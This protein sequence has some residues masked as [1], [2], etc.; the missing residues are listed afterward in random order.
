MCITSLE[1]RISRSSSFAQDVLTYTSA[2][3]EKDLAAVGPVKVK[4]WAKSS[5][6]DTDFVVK[7]VDV[8]PSGFAQNI[9]ERVIRARFRRG[10]KLPPQLMVPG[11]PYEF[12]LDLGYAGSLFKAGHRVRLDIASSK[13]PHLARNQNTGGHPSTDA[14]MEVA[15]NSILHGPAHP[16]YVELSIVPSLETANR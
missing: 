5:A 11:Q 15:A 12:E 1:R 6:R 4:F 3:L 2:P 16:S 9:L 7:L 14:R 13:F 8:R 10:S